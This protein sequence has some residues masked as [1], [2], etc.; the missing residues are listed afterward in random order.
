[1]KEIAIEK[2]LRDAF[3]AV[4]G[5]CLKLESAS[6]RGM[7]DRIVIYRGQIVFV[8]LKAPGWEPRPLQREVHE[9]LIKAGA[10]VR[11]IDSYAGVDSLLRELGV[12]V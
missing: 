6:S 5:L 9:D 7:P 1:M 4:G 8:E 12:K 10:R 3:V 2:K 11:V